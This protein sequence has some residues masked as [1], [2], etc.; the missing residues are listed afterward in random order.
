MHRINESF[1]IVHCVVDTERGPG[2]CFEA[3]SAQARLSTQV[4][5]ADGDVRKIEQRGEVEGVDAVDSERGDGSFVFCATDETET[6]DGL[7]PLFK[8][9]VQFLFVLSNRFDANALDEIEG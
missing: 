7:Q 3:E 9:P 5:T 6:V 4:A 1:H 8:C 2:C